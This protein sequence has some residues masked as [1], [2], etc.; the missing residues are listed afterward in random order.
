MPLRRA[1]IVGNREC[2]DNGHAL[3]GTSR[4]RNHTRS[5]W[6][7]HR[8][9]HGVVYRSPEW[10][11]ARARVLREQP[12]CAVEDCIARSSEVDHITPLSRGGAPF[13]REN[14]RGLCSNHHRKR[15]SQQGGEA[16]KRKRQGRLD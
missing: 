4:C 10:K 8:P 9:E 3:P 15:S 16:K 2:S 12:V 11:S 13:A 1:C 7:V 14:L 5:N 6:G